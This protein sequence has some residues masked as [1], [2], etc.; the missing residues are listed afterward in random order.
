M[1]S[2]ESLVLVVDSNELDELDVSMSDGMETTVLLSLF[3]S[4]TVVLASL[5][6]GCVMFAGWRLLLGWGSLTSRLIKSSL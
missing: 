3:L 2:S 1:L 5:L 4:S 6:S